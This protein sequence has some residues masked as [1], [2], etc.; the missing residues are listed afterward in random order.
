M[1]CPGCRAGRSSMLRLRHP[2]PRVRTHRSSKL[3]HALDARPVVRLAVSIHEGG[4]HHLPVLIGRGHPAGA[5]LP[6][7]KGAQTAAAW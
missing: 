6:H 7:R 1:S 2:A 3:L 4:V 5:H